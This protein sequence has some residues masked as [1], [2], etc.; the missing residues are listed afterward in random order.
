MIHQQH[1][2]PP[3]VTIQQLQQQQVAHVAEIKS[4]QTYVIAK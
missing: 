3:P 1:Q 4:Q 2:P